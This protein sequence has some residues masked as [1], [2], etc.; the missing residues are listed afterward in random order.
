MAVDI[1]S[2]IKAAAAKAAEQAVAAILRR[3]L[4]AQEY[5]DT[6]QAAA[7][8]GLSTQRLEIWR[9]RGGGPV[10]HKM[11]NAVRYKRSELDDFMAGLRVANTAEAAQRKGGAR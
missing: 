6:R 10:Y 1:E 3:G 9:C 5:M 8:L 7:Y 4:P 11:D 2:T